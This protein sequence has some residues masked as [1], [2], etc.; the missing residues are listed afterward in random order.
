M[1]HQ[2]ETRGAED[3]ID[4][5][6]PSPVATLPQ[7]AYLSKRRVIDL[8]RG[9]VMFLLSAYCLSKLAGLRDKE[10]E[11]LASLKAVLL[12]G[13]LKKRS[14]DAVDG[15]L[16]GFVAH[17]LVGKACQA[18]RWAAA[19]ELKQRV[20][21][22]AVGLAR[23]AVPS[24]RRMIE[25]KQS[26]A[27]GD[28][29]KGMLKSIGD[30]Y[31]QLPKKGVPHGEVV[32][33]LRRRWDGDHKEQWEGGRV[34]GAIYQCAPDM[35]ALHKE[36]L[37]LYSVT[38][39]LHPDLHPSVRQMEAECIRMVLDVFHGG[40]D[41]CGCMTSGGTE[42]ILLALKAYRE[43]GREAKG[44]SEP[45]VVVCVTA[46]AAFDKAGDYFG[47]KIV[48]VPF[49][50][51]TGRMDLAA[52]RRAINANTVALVGSAPN[53][54]HGVIDPIE[55][56]ARIA[57]QHTLGL[58]VDACLGSFIAGHLERAGF[59]SHTRFD[60]RVAGVTSISCDTHKYGFAPKGSS[61]LMYSDEALRQR[62]FFTCVEW[63]GGIYAS[64]TM[65]G[66]RVGAAVAATWAALMAT[67]ED[68]YIRATKKV[69][70]A[71]RKVARG[72]QDTPHLRVVGSPELS[73]VAFTSDTIPVYAVNEALKEVGGWHL[74]ALQN[75]PA[76]HLC[77]TMPVAD[78][79]DVFVA[80]LWEAVRRVKA[81]P[82]KYDRG[83][84]ALYG[85]AASVP[86]DLVSDL[87][88]KYFDV[89]Y[90]PA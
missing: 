68:G 58:H 27:M 16:L 66:S 18:W 64:P 14:I 21:A 26:A 63:L 51:D 61:V 37:G 7:E 76:V 22:V 28:M 38:N 34:S 90:T 65:A 13:L 36:A 11:Q 79:V 81:D 46:H 19:P 47:I 10:L 30:S 80:H 52:V 70:E 17:Y 23:R 53:F 31:T 1:V 57:K 67:G 71:A 83:G 82:A 55:E 40:P 62:Q 35:S 69:I 42:S 48:K 74:N 59:S 39:P 9:A 50:P 2:K 15:L 49:C 24:V 3:G 87:S 44:I 4:I 6:S 56:L 25:E 20:L 89:V 54:P 73:I 8:V 41:T 60:F 43:W 84:A 29:R 75:P 78:Q 86:K 12:Q 32:A 77:V 5:S 88:R 45:E 33:L 72:V 85:M